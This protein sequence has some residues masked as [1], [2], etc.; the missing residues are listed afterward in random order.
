MPGLRYRPRLLPFSKN[1]WSLFAAGQSC[2][3]PLLT[4]LP[5]SSQ[6]V[7]VVNPVPVPVLVVA[8]VQKG[9]RRP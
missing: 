8:A 6:H 5:T 7:K 1:S 3:D 9:T 2:V 4:L